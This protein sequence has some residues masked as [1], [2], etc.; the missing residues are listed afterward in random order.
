MCEMI[1]AMLVTLSPM[2]ELMSVL[3]VTI[4]N[5][6]KDGVSLSFA[7][8]EVIRTKQPIPHIFTDRFSGW[9]KRASGARICQGVRSCVGG[10]LWKKASL[11]LA[12]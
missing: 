8:G 7:T 1:P 6:Y 5:I 9:L 4:S 2:A 11:L 3:P 12:S 10:S